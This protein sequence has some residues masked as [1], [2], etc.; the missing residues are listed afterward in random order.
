MAEHVQGV[1]LWKNEKGQTGENKEDQK[2]KC[3]Y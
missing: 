2:R 3:N 1:R